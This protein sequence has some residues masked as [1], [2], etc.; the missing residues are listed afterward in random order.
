MTQQQMANALGI[1][2]STYTR[3]EQGKVEMKASY[4]PLIAQALGMK[5]EQLAAIIF[6]QYVA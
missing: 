4:L 1:D 5:V 6:S 3:I 2:R